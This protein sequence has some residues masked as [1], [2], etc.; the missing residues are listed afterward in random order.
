MID[1]LYEKKL[2]SKDKNLDEKLEYEM[3]EL[4][5]HEGCHARFGAVMMA[6]DHAWW[7]GFYELNMTALVFNKNQLYGIK[8]T[9]RQNL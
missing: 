3:Y 9:V 2:L 6:L 4:W 7:H 1:E 8:N 5:H